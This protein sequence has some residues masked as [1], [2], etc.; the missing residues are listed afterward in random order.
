M[1]HL[2][3][4]DFLARV[5]RDHAGQQA[6]EAPPILGPVLKALRA[7]DASLEGKT[8]EFSGTNSVGPGWLIQS[9]PQ[10]S[11]CPLLTAI[12]NLLSQVV[13][14]NPGTAH[15]IDIAHLGTAPDNFWMLDRIAEALVQLAGHSR[16]PI[17]VRYL[18]GNPH[19]PDK[20]HAFAFANKVLE[21]T[22]GQT[23]LAN[24]RMFFGNLDVP[25]LLGIDD[26]LPG[27][28]NHAKIFA[29]DGASSIVGGMNYWGDY[30]PG[31]NPLY[32]VAIQ[33]DGQA[34]ASSQRYADYLWSAGVGYGSWSSHRS[35]TLGDSELGSAMPPSFSSFP[36]P[37][38]ASGRLPVL[39]VGNLGLW[40]I[41]DQRML[42]EEYEF[43]LHFE[44]IHP[45]NTYHSLM[46]SPNVPLRFPFWRW[47]YGSAAAQQASAAA[48]HLVLQQMGQGQRIRV[49]QQK[50]ADT[51][52]AN[53]S[54]PAKGFV[55]WPGNFLDDM[56]GALR[57]GADVDILLSHHEAYYS[58]GYSDDMGGEALRG[59]IESRAGTAS[60]TL[61]IRQ[62][63]PG[64]YN[65]GKVWIADDQAFFVGSDN[66]Y[67]GYLQEYG[68]VVADQA[69]THQFVS[70]YWDPIWQEAVA[71]S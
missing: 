43:N 50:I 9:K 35:L 61:T 56:A 32:D 31:G 8:Y 14:Q 15:F 54:D 36:P 27:S 5:A 21:M 51:D 33:V 41:R 30:R 4:L 6:D 19:D 29:A 52:T 64:V 66:I 25:W 37:P 63:P 62:T 11:D 47:D 39:G 23:Q 20:P 58:G 53:T 12:E 46:E 48:R 40:G 42:I 44:P 26:R 34:A 24:M 1:S 69:L 22:R 13:G 17:T 16:Q 28:W 59:V 49:S 65:H 2:E 10:R 3:H 38:P 70:D 68:Y 60:G 55:V 45:Q 57:R 7:S 67:P 71:V 18:E